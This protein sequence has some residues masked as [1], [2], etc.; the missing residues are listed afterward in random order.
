MNILVPILFMIM[1]LIAIVKVINGIIPL[2]AKIM[3]QAVRPCARPNRVL[4]KT[5]MLRKPGQ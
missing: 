3:L 1:N 2:I 5:N 4:L